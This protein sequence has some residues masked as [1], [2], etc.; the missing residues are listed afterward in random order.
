VSPPGSVFSLLLLGVSSDYVQDWLGIIRWLHVIAAIMWI[1]ITAYFVLVDNVLLPPDEEGEADGV[2]GERYW[3]H[4]GGFYFMRRYSWGPRQL[5]PDIYWHPQWYAYTTWLSGLGLLIVVYYW[6][7]G[8][9]LVDPNVADLSATAAVIISVA[10][11]AVA[12][13]VYDAISRLLV[14][15][16]RLLALVLVGLIAGAALGFSE[17]FSPRG[18]AIQVGA[19]IGT[20]MAGN[21]VFVFS[22][23]HRRQFAAKET[24]RE[25]DPAWVVRSAQ[26]G[27]HNTFFA[28]PVLFAMLSG[29]FSFVYGSE[30]P[31]EALIIVMLVGASLRYFFVRRQQGR[32]IW[33]IPVTGVITLGLLAVW[34][35]PPTVEDSQGESAGSAG[36]SLTR[37][38]EIYTA[39]G[40]SSCHTLA[41]AGSEGRVGPNLDQAK[42]SLELVKQR[43]TEGM[44]A[45]PSFQG[46]LD[47]AEIEA[48]ADYVSKVAGK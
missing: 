32:R 24:G 37:G 48:L 30:H 18:M 22:P 10:S 9:Y 43:V 2:Q 4:G 23:A 31:W 44:G 46:Q 5:P 36:G 19:I 41:D 25:I 38:K 39:S 29:H 28:L 45:M 1:G 34:L 13:L 15:R 3:L 8:S 14:H 11:L 42:P 12:W 7:A 6:K 40:C 21:V 33:A 17:L 26:R 20:L 16:P 27:A 35:A 47:T